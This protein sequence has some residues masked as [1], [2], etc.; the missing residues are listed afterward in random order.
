MPPPMPPVAT[1]VLM[2]Q[3]SATRVFVAPMWTPPAV[4]AV[5]PKTTHRRIASREAPI[6]KI[7]PPTEV[8]FNGDEGAATPVAGAASPDESPGSATETST[9]TPDTKTPDGE[10]KSK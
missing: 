3:S 5:F 2:T 9:K 10:E 4:Y 8:G 1:F 7:P 6:V